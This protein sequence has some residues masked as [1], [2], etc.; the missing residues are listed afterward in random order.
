MKAIEYQAEILS[1]LQKGDEILLEGLYKIH[2]GSV[3]TASSVQKP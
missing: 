3:I 2:D 1:G